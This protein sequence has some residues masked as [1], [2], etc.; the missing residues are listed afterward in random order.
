MTKALISLHAW[1]GWSTPLLFANPKDR[2]SRVKAH[3]VGRSEEW[4][5]EAHL[6]FYKPTKLL[7]FR[8]APSYIGRNN[9]YPV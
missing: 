8:Q 6:G 5:S 2:F 9:F 7:L 1:A 3:M 4:P